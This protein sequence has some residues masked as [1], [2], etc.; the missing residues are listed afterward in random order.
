M[1]MLQAVQVKFEVS[2]P[3]LAVNP[4]LNLTLIP[5]SCVQMHFLG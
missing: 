5:F 4:G 1:Y 2:A 3:S